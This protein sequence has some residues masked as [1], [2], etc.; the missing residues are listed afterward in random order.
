MGP[1]ARDL[2][3]RWEFIWLWEAEP[4]VLL[5]DQRFAK[6]WKAVYFQKERWGP[7][8]LWSKITL[9]IFDKIAKSN[10]VGRFKR[11]GRAGMCCVGD[12]EK[13][14]GGAWRVAHTL[15]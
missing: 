12:G 8:F 6:D 13:W 14:K 1:G 5:G 9:A 10:A 2:G 15:R 4:W 3:E 11:G 7:A